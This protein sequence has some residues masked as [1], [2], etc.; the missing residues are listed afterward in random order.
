MLLSYGSLARVKKEAFERRTLCETVV[1]EE[2]KEEERRIRVL[3][4][5]FMSWNDG[6]RVSISLV[7]GWFMGWMA[8]SGSG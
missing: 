6:R 8:G 1:A 3:K 5:I 2:L 7:G 4:Q